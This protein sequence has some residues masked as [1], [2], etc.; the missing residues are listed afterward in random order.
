MSKEKAAIE[1]P[2]V[3][4]QDVGRIR[5]II[6]GSQMRDYDQRF[7]NVTRDLER[8]QQA[9]DDLSGQLADQDSQQGKKLQSLRQ[10][11]RRADD[12]LRSEL[13]QTAENLTDAKVDRIALGELF[14]E[15]G[16]HLKQG[17][18]LVDLLPG[19]KAD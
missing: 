2:D 17:G 5:E 10:E 15:L 14:V 8:L 19:Q 12:D 16:T 13:R 11:M 6:F 18:S 1:P 3:S 9:L 4:S 7:Q